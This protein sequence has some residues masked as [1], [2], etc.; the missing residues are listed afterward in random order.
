MGLE[1]CDVGVISA[2]DRTRDFIFSA[3][4]AHGHFIAYNDDISGFNDE[5]LPYARSP[6]S[7]HYLRK[8]NMCTRGGEGNLIHQALDAALACKRQETG[9]ICAIFLDGVTAKRG[10][11]RE[12]GDISSLW[13]LPVL[14]ILTDRGIVQDA[15]RWMGHSK[16][17]VAN[18]FGSATHFIVAND[19][20]KVYAFAS[21]AVAYVRSNCSPFLL[22]LQ[23]NGTGAQQ[24]VSGRR[25]AN[26]TDDGLGQDPL[27]KIARY[28]TLRE[29]ELIE[30]FVQE[31]IQEAVDGAWLT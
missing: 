27:Q 6:D 28:L 17:D 3:Y 24:E 31:R 4:R 11:M 14:F 2:L 25:A 15:R 12:I 7:H 13:S 21:A 30:S 10:L 1:A 18:A 8:F 16:G 5:S 29:R 22:W 26:R 23:T 20:F 9:A 19:V